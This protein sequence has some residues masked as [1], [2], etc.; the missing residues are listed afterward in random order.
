MTEKG[1][2]NF[3]F[4]TF[5]FPAENSFSYLPNDFFL[6]KASGDR[7]LIL[8][9]LDSP[10]PKLFSEKIFILILFYLILLLLILFLLISAI[11]MGKRRVKVGQKLETL[12]LSLFLKSLNP[13][14]KFETMILFAIVLSLVKRA[15][16]LR[17]NCYFM[18]AK[19]VGKSLQILTWRPQM[20]YLRNFSWLCILMRLLTKHIF[21]INQKPLRMSQKFS[22]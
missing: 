20:L 8:T 6:R 3:W 22:F 2:V 18:D 14:K 17:K 13:S 5:T 11:F 7:V 21:S 9:H 15:Q 16:N 10:M 4:W 19:S 1:Y 12:D